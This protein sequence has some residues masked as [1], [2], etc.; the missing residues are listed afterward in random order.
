MTGKLNLLR[1]EFLFTF[2]IYAS[3]YEKLIF[4]DL[5]LRVK[6]KRGYR[7]IKNNKLFFFKIFEAVD[8][9]FNAAFAHKNF[10]LYYPIFKRGHGVKVYGL[11]WAK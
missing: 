10:I 3:N 8:L 11:Y 6:G 4:F 9:G 1:F 5:N 7:V 2:L